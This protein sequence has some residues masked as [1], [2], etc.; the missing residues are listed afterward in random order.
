MVDSSLGR[1][2][3]VTTLRTP[4]L[5][6]FT[7]SSWTLSRPNTLVRPLVMETSD[8]VPCLVSIGTDI[9]GN[10]FSD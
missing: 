8:Y 6:F 2:S 4:I 1:I 3:S 7:S 10:I 9:Q 5:V